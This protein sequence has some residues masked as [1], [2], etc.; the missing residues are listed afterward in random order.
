MDNQ[1]HSGKKV[2]LLPQEFATVQK[3]KNRIMLFGIL[4]LTSCGIVIIIAITLNPRIKNLEEIVAPLRAEVQQNRPLEEQLKPMLLELELAFTAENRS[5]KEQ[6]EN[7]LISQEPAWNA[8]LADLGAASDEKV[9][10][11][12]LRLSNS[13][14]DEADKEIHIK[15]EASDYPQVMAF[16]KRMAN[17]SHLTSFKPE[18]TRTTNSAQH[19]GAAVIFEAKGI[20]R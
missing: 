13:T 20:I 16:I 12:E 17:S 15:G 2:D 18:F 5:L 4:C 14:N 19:T 8:L 11:T 10:M 1:E 3:V 7:A 6:K 9:W